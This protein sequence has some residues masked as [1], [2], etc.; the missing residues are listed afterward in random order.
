MRGLVQRPAQG[1]RALAGEM[2]RGAVGVGLVDGDVHPGVADDVA[3]VG[4]AA[5]VAELRD[6]GD[7]GQ[8][9]DAVELAHECASAGLFAGDRPQFA[10]KRGQLEL[11]R[12]DHVQGDLELFARSRRE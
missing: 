2:A 1:G 7:R 12:V 5:D 6:D 10:V 4:E 8:L 9:A 3:R 11:E